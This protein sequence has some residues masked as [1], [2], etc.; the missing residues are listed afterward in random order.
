MAFY[1]VTALEVGLLL[2]ALALLF[3]AYKVI[4]AVKPFIVN[5]IV[6]I[7]ALLAVQAL[8][9]EVAITPVAILITALAG[10]PGAVLVTLLALLEIAFVPGA[11]PVPLA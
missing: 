7:L 11:I 2:V 9:F 8:G 4:R 10:L 3:G 6:G 1:M 5:A